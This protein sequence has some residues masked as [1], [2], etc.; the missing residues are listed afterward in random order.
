MSDTILKEIR[1]DHQIKKFCAYGF[2]KNLKFFE[3]YLLIF[4]M[5]KGLSLFEIGILI[6]I[7]E[8]I[9][10]LFEIPSGL[11]ADYFGRKKELYV[12][13]AF[14]ILSF[15]CCF[16]LDSFL[17][18]ALAMILFGLG[19]AFRSGTHKAMIYTYLDQKG[20]Q[21][22]KTFVY[23]RTRSFSL[24]GSAV[25]ALLGILL[26]LLAPSVN[27]IFLF[28][29][30]P[31]ILD[32]LLIL[33]YPDSLDRTD[34]KTELNFRQMFSDSLKHLKE[35]A[36]LRHL[37]L[38][39]G[40]FE[41]TIAFSKDM[42][43][44]ILEAIILGS[45]LTV[46]VSMSREDNLHILLGL[47]YAG[48]NLFGS[49]ASQKAYILRKRKGCIKCL[50]IIHLGLASAI[51]VLAAAVRNSWAVLL[52]Y[53]LI[54]FLFNVRKPI[55]VDEI[56]EHIEKSSRATVLSVAS[57]LKSLFLMILAPSA[58]WIA[59]HFGLGTMMLLLSLFFFATLPLLMPGKCKK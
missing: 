59:D 3:P 22:Q 6:G 41:S 30:I 27:Y 31:Y 15:L 24:I 46:L 38:E 25:S 28:S 16:I 20:W 51:A 19:E 5:S 18:A 8:I 34:K 56:D 48:L 55:F 39:E 29:V 58:G 12:C 14:Y 44:P 42:I 23:G 37:L 10:N 11:I 35:T 47:V 36:I 1:S 57:Q 40:I 13:F 9:I 50:F 54:Y 53:L 17:T 32:L 2:L 49:I 7:R 26:I 4:L 33:S 45:G 43:Q 52:I 21:K